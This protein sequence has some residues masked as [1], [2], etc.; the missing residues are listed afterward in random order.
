[1][2]RKALAVVLSGALISTGCASAARGAMQSPAVVDPAMMAEYVQRIPAGSRV[3]VERTNGESMRGTLMKATPQAITVQRNTRIPEP[4]LEIPLGSV[5]RVTLDS[6]GGGAST[7][8]AIGIGVA[9]GVGTFFVILA[10]L[11]A[12]WDD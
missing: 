3:R 6:A 2:L 9:S 4:P 5:A 12:A 11:A 10:I 8:K 1:M 7:A